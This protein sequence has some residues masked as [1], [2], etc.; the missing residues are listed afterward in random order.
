ML[1]YIIDVLPETPGFVKLDKRRFDLKR[2]FSG[3]EIYW[4][5]LKNSDWLGV[6]QFWMREDF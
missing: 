1:S 5:I 3:P 4:K 6:L 2:A